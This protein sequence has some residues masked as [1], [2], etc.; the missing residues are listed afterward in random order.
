MP[1]AI[2]PDVTSTIR[3]PSRYS[4]AAW[5]QTC[6]STSSRTSP[7]SSATMLDPSLM[8][9]ALTRRTLSA[10]RRA[11]VELEQRAG[12]LHVV[13]RLEARRLERADHA[14]RAQP[15]LDVGERLVVVDVVARE[16]PLYTRTTHPEHAVGAAL[17]AEALVRARPVHAVL[18]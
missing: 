16:Q 10:E 3:R 17:D 8:T 2:A 18:S 5:S 13:A 1:R 4:S 9:V 14:D 12:D 15:L 7:R 6:A 11:R